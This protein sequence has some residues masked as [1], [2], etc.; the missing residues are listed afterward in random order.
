M[1]LFFNALLNV[2]MLPLMVN[3]RFYVGSKIYH[4]AHFKLIKSYND[5]NIIYLFNERVIRVVL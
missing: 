4:I 2:I 1:L 3:K 5:T